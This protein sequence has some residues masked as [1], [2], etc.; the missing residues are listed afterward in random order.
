MYLYT[1]CTIYCKHLL[2]QNAL[3]MLIH[4]ICS[5]EDLMMTHSVQ[6]KH[7]A[8]NVIIK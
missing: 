4:W 8:L 7:V 3:K 2:S 1:D 6:S 5:P